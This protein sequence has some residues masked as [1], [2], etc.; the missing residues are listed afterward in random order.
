[1]TIPEIAVSRKMVKV[2]SFS[3]G[4]L[5]GYEHSL[6]SGTSINYAI[7]VDS[8]SRYMQVVFSRIS[9]PSFFL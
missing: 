7:F 9:K 1:M 6:M 5:C 3:K 8:L 2:V 4:N